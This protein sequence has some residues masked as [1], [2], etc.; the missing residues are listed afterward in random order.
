[1]T[2]D[3]TTDADVFWLDGATVLRPTRRL[4][5][6]YHTTSCVR[7]TPLVVA[8]PLCRLVPESGFD[9]RTSLI[10][11]RRRAGDQS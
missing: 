4:E 9:R 11:R 10:W 1:M 2:I 7:T 5:D 3:G 8:W 6:V